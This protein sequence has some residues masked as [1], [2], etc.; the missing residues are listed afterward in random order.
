MVFGN[1]LL[2]EWMYESIHG[3]LPPQ[4]DM[5]LNPYLF[6]GWVGIFITGLNLIPIGQLDGGHLLY[7]LIGRSAHLVSYAILGSAV[8][9][10][11]YTSNYSFALMIV[12]LL[13]M[14][15]RH[16]PTADDS[17]PL[18]GFRILIGWLSLSFVIVGLTPEPLKVLS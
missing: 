17:V 5:L 12:L 7:T 8:T 4:H 9:Y 1:P 13:L 10:M 18:G 6:A 15:P 11:V 16:P 2:L 14:G 3:P